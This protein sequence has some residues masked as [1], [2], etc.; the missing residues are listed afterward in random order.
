MKRPPLQVPIAVRPGPRMPSTYRAALEAL[1][2]ER[3]R[4]LAGA[5]VAGHGGEER[6]SLELPEGNVG[7][8]GDRRRSR[9]V[10]QEGDLAEAVAR[11]EPAQ[12]PPVAGHVKRARPDEVEA[13]ARLPL[14]DQD[15]ARRPFR[16]PE[17]AGEALEL[18]PRQ[19]GEDRRAA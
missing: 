15:I 11:P 6:R 12:R 7:A 9:N 17:A 3:R 4:R 16:E 10:V 13:V 19:R 2:A 1:P 5:H 14:A 18:R 8:G